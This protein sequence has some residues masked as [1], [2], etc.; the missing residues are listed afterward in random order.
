MFFV[1]EAIGEL[2]ASIAAQ[3]TGEAVVG[4]LAAR[5]FRGA[6]VSCDIRAAGG[7]A[8]N[9]D[10]EWTNGLATVTP[11]HISFAP[12][13]GVV[14]LKGIVHDREIDV[15]LVA[16]FRLGRSRTDERYRKA[17]IVELVTPKGNLEWSLDTSQLQRAGD[18]LAGASGVRGEPFG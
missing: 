15:D 6:I 2:F 12:S 13:T 17:T 18:L 7:R 14:P 4:A 10:A 5:P 1:F 11:G 16:T 8:Y 9:L 3:A